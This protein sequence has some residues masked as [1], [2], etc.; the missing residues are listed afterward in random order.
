MADR[1]SAVR[2][3]FQLLLDN[4]SPLKNRIEFPSDISRRQ[5]Y[6]AF[7]EDI[8]Y[9]L[10]CDEP[11]VT[12]EFNGIL[13]EFVIAIIAIDSRIYKISSLLEAIVGH[14]KIG[15]RIRAAIGHLITLMLIARV[16]QLQ[17][18]KTTADASP[19][20]QSSVFDTNLTDALVSVLTD[21]T[22]DSSAWCQKLYEFLIFSLTK[23]YPPYTVASPIWK[24]G[25]CTGIPKVQSSLLGFLL[26]GCDDGDN[27]DDEDIRSVYAH[28]CHENQKIW[29][30]MASMSPSVPIVA[31]SMRLLLS[32]LRDK[33]TTAFPV[34]IHELI[35]AQI[36]H[37]VLQIRDL[38]AEF[39][40]ERVDG[41]DIMLTELLHFAYRFQVGG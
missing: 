3:L 21:L 6:I 26:V 30:K 36:F 2:A 32:L 11:N 9:P 23:K 13:H 38:A 16:R 7:L 28:F 34:S 10:V 15:L 5:Q 40:R 25:L 29:M 4:L 18:S 41:G 33:K 20:L 27:N 31:G 17:C 19:P 24:L 12:N 14:Q 1:A 35:Y 22:Y 39:W 37:N 8:Q